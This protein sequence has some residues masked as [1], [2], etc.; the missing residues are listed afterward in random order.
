MVKVLLGQ[1]GAT[2]NILAFCAVG[3]KG[4]KKH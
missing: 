4:T 1:Q 3:I 2:Q